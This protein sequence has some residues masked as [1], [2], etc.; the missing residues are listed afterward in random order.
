MYRYVSSSLARSTPPLLDPPP[1]W[2][3][4]PSPLGPPRPMILGPLSFVS[5]LANGEIP[6]P[7]CRARARC[8]FAESAKIV[9]SC[10]IHEERMLD[11]LNPHEDGLTVVEH[12]LIGT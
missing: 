3:G 11:L 10:Q 9:F 1:L 8:L 4:P 7:L 6:P 2:A 5:P 12:P